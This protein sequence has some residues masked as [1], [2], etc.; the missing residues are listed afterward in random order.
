MWLTGSYLDQISRRGNCN[1]QGAGC[2]TGGDLEGEGCIFAG[3]NPQG[4]DVEGLH[5]VVQTYSQPAKETLPV[6]T[7]ITFQAVNK[8]WCHC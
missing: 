2:Q 8:W 6:Q 4:L 1:P 5:R 3:V 7:C